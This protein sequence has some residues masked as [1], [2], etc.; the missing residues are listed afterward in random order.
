[1]VAKKKSQKSKTKSK[2][3]VEQRLSRLE[4]R[5][6]LLKASVEDLIDLLEGTK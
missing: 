6:D 3:T 2:A 4:K 5:V 1:M